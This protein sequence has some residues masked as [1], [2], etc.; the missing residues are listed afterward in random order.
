MNPAEVREG[1]LVGVC[2]ASDD[3]DE[4][5]LLAARDLGL[6]PDLVHS[7]DDCVDLG[8]GRLV[9]H[10]DDHGIIV[11]RR[12]WRSAL[13]ASAPRMYAKWIEDCGRGVLYSTSTRM[14]I[15]IPRG[16]GSLTSM[17]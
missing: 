13:I 6:Q 1:F 17:S 9:R 10:Y 2:V 15:G 16:L 5:P 8:L 14:H 3:P 12:D 4:G 7:V 11:P